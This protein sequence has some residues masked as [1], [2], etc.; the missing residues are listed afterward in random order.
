MLTVLKWILFIIVLVVL[1]LLSFATAYVFSWPWWSAWVVFVVL[2]SVIA[3]GIV[4]IRGVIAWNKRR[5]SEESLEMRRQVKEERNVI[6]SRRSGLTRQWRQMIRQLH[7]SK[8]KTRGNPVYALPWYLMLGPSQAGKTAAIKASKLSVP[9]GGQAGGKEKG[10]VGGS[11][12]WLLEE[13]LVLDIPGSYA[14]HRNPGDRAEWRQFLSLLN[15]HRKDM[16]INGAVLTISA[17]LLLNSGDDELREHAVTLRERMD[18]M[19]QRLGINFPVYVLVTKCDQVQ[20]LAKFFQHFPKQVYNQAM[21]VLNDRYAEQGVPERFLARAFRRI[22]R[23]L[24]RLRLTMLG[25]TDPVQIDARD[26]VFPEEFRSL[27]KPLQ[28]MVKLVFEK[29]S[30]HESPYFRAIY[31]SSAEQAGMPFSSILPNIGFPE[32]NLPLPS[33][34]LSFFLRDFFGKVLRTDKNLVAP[35]R[36]ALGLASM[37]Q[38]AWAM[39]WIVLSIILGILLSTSF[40]RNLTVLRQAAGEIPATVSVAGNFDQDIQNLDRFR[41]AIYKLVQ[42][43]KDWWSPALMLTQS[44]DVE[45]KLTAIYS[46][47]FYD[48]ILMPVDRDILK[49]VKRLNKRSEPTFIAKYIDLFSKRINLLDKVR[50][51]DDREL[52]NYVG[53][54][55]DFEVM[56]GKKRVPNNRSK[57]PSRMRDTYSAYLLWE[58]DGRFLQAEYERQKVNLQGILSQDDLGLNWLTAW[59]NIQETLKDITLR[60]F[61]GN[62]LPGHPVRVRRAFTPKGY[63]AIKV[64]I[65]RMEEVQVAKEILVIAREEFEKRYRSQYLMEWENF[66]REFHRGEELFK[67]R[68]QR[69]ELATQ[70]STQDSPFKK[71]FELIGG[72]LIQ[73]KLGGGVLKPPIDLAKNKETLPYWVTQ[74]ATFKKLQQPTYQK[75]LKGESTGARIPGLRKLDSLKRRFGSVISQQAQIRRD[76]KALEFVEG[77]LSTIDIM[78]D[79]AVASTA[80]FETAKKSFAKAKAVVT[81]PSETVLLNRWSQ[82]K[83]KQTLTVSGHP[84]EEVFWNL[85]DDQFRILWDIILDEAERHLQELWEEEVMA[86]V[87]S[88]E[89]KDKRDTLIGEAGKTWEFRDKYAKDFLETRGGAYRPKILYKESVHFTQAFLDVLTK[90]KITIRQAKK[91]CP[92]T[93]A[94]LPTDTDR[95]AVVRPFRTDLTLK[96]ETEYKLINLQNNPLGKAFVWTEDGCG[97]VELAISVGTLVL[98]KEYED[99][100]AFL[101]DFRHGGSRTFRR[102]EFRANAG[103]LTGYGVN[104]IIVKYNF[105]GQQCVLNRQVRKQKLP[106]AVIVR[107]K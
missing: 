101:R 81:K 104:R 84:E 16:P 67:N 96:C 9:F 65:E 86:Q 23:R 61:W 18:D 91:E 103:Q 54:L 21:G 8:F 52:E 75:V 76:R 59:A 90:G 7:R 3:L 77:Y 100:A 47:Q 89:P 30:F 46:K 55:P 70:M 36:R 20:G 25:N 69:L 73:E 74:F 80:A 32:E 92:V 6:W 83:L 60:E 27:E 39:G 17:D 62:D 56:L 5:N 41:A 107:V 63:A 64:F 79:T 11:R 53:T 14:F 26:F 106:P 19:V 78:S 10:Y 29:R 24:D 22:G 66:L 35:T 1:G 45:D 37:T 42:R 51:D 88:M 102:L 99:F 95:T 31:F 40:T 34:Q 105:R 98:K 28:I 13:T 87:Q 50:N 93:I 71:L 2:L 82:R 33:G 58:Q 4:T 15:R 43:N 72:G 94:A 44:W 48:F 12:W 38:N 68:E 85:M 97:K 57:N 49:T